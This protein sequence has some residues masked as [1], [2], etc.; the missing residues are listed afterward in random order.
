MAFKLLTLFFVASSKNCE[1]CFVYYILLK[2]FEKLMMPILCN[3]SWTASLSNQETVEYSFTLFQIHL[4]DYI[5]LPCNRKSQTSGLVKQL[6]LQIIVVR[7]SGAPCGAYR[8]LIKGGPG[9]RK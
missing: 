3:L 7:M 4:I 6:E 9:L 8:G 1:S 2:K 5:L